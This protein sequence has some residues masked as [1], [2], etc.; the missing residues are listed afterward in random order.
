MKERERETTPTFPRDNQVSTD[1]N[2]VVPSTSQISLLLEL[3]FPLSICISISIKI[4]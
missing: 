1:V 2:A 3:S 4:L